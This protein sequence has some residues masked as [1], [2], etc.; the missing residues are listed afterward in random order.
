MKNKTERAK[1][2]TYLKKKVKKKRIIL[3]VIILL[4][5]VTVIK[6]R[7]TENLEYKDFTWPDTALAKMLPDPESK[8]GE[9]LSDS[10]DYLSVNVA[11]VGRKK[12]KAYYKKCSESGFNVDYSSSDIFYYADDNNGYKL[13]IDYDEKK[14]IMGIEISAPSEENIQTEDSGYPDSNI[15]DSDSANASEIASE[16]ETDRTESSETLF[17]SVEEESVRPEVKDA[18]DSY[19]SFMNEY[20]DF[21]NKYNNSDDTVSMLADYAKYMKKYTE[22]TKK[23]DDIESMDL[24][25]AENLYFLDVQ[26]RV[27]AKLAEIQ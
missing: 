21:M 19:E 25:D 5:L 23:M 10:E 1:E 8:W 3:G 13:S 4:A 27:N 24:N 6:A 2:D 20:V 15:Q 18:L 7:V 17:Q 16:T 14:K 22:M 9:V 12:F 26:T 11:K